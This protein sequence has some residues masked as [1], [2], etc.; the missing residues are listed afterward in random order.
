MAKYRVTFVG[1][2][3]SSPTKPAKWLHLLAVSGQMAAMALLSFTAVSIILGW[4][5][6]KVF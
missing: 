2:Q 3:Q 4:G 1:E 6:L 5:G